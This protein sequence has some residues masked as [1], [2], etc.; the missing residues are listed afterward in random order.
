MYLLLFFLNTIIRFNF[1]WELSI[2]STTDIRPQI[3]FIDYAYY[4]C[5]LLVQFKILDRRYSFSFCMDGTTPTVP[6]LPIFCLIIPINMVVNCTKTFWYS[7]C[8]IIIL[9]SG[10]SPTTAYFSWTCTRYQNFTP[11]LHIQKIYIRSF[12]H[13]SACN[14]LWKFQQHGSVG[15]GSYRFNTKAQTHLVL[16]RSILDVHT[17]EVIL[18]S[19]NYTI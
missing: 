10:T 9:H 1:L 16:Y 8:T 6:I 15:E 7:R 12:N 18:W 2:V 19:L 3:F 13:Q 5:V 14:K 11:T 4:E 17:C